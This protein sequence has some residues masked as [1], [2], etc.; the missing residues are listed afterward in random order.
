MNYYFEIL[1]ILESN[2]NKELSGVEIQVRFF[3]KYKGSILG[4]NKTLRQ[5]RK[6]KDI[7]YRRGK[8]LEGNNCFYKYVGMKK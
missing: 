2:K 6:R 1:E 4:V 3:K 8:G 5:L 7:K